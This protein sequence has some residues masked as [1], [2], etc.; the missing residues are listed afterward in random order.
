VGATVE[1]GELAIQDDPGGASVWYRWTAP[2]TPAGGGMVR[3][4]TCTAYPGVNGHIEAFVGN[5][6]SSLHYW[7]PGPGSC[8][9]G[10]AG[11][12]VVVDWAPGQT[13]Y[14]KFDGINNRDG[15]GPSEGP[16]TLEWATQ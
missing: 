14:L 5:S 13:I 15:L 2:T 1:P 16:F 10:Q 6:V 3:F 11:A 8:P 7:G 12:Y 9:P 4:D